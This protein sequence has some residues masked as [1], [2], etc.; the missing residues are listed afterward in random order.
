MAVK[1]GPWDS[2]IVTKPV[3]DILCTYLKYS[4]VFWE[5]SELLS[6]T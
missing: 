1:R 6:W 3:L 2:L 4:R 5:F